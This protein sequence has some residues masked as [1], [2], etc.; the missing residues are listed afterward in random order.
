MKKLYSL[1]GI[2]LFL[3]SATVSLADSAN[4][5]GK[6]NT[7]KILDN[8]EIE[9]TTEEINI[10]IYP[11]MKE[12]EEFVP[13]ID[14]YTE[15]EVIYVFTNL[16][17]TE[18]T[19][20]MGFPEK[21][22]DIDE[23]CFESMENVSDNFANQYKLNEF[24]A[25]DK[26]KNYQIEFRNDKTSVTPGVN[27][28]IYQVDFAPNEK[29][30]IT[31]KYWISNSSYKGSS[32][33]FSYILETGA[34]W[35]NSIGEIDVN[36]YFKDGLSVYDIN[37]ATP[38]GYTLNK[39][40]NSIHHKFI[41][42]EPT[43]ND[44]L[45]INYA[46]NTILNDWFQILD[47]DECGT[48]SS[49]FPSKN[50]TIYNACMAQ[51]NDTNT[52]WVEG[53][54]GNGI[55]EWFEYN[56][57]Y[58]ETDKIYNQI[59]IINGYARDNDIWQKNNRIKK[60][61]FTTTNN[62]TINIELEDTMDLQTFVYNETFY[63]NP[64]TKIYIDEIYQGSKYNDTALSE[65]R[66][67]GLG[68][69]IIN[70]NVPPQAQEGTF[71]DVLDN[72]PFQE[73]I[74]QLFSVQIIQGYEDGTYKPT[75]LI[76]RAEFTKIIIEA[77]IKDMNQSSPYEPPMGG[78]NCFSDVQDQWFAKYICGAKKGGIINGYS[79][80]TFRPS[81]SINLAEALKIVLE[82]K[83]KYVEDINLQESVVWYQKYFDVADL[84]DLFEKIAHDPAKNI[85]RG[86]MAQIIFVLFL[87]RG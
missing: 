39:E 15:V 65:I 31:N 43:N 24:K 78:E 45:E 73:A 21:C 16:S 62:K 4:L 68:K 35:K 70:P 10:N 64:D 2:C 53:V 74:E 14:G 75:Y 17:E 29:K 7:V 46:D 81:D 20:T 57:T 51:D 61:H 8:S 54:D 76:N 69:G 6:G 49:F 48:S 66:F 47:A 67:K 50:E 37:H 9:M 41:N 1:L 42:L 11:S 55:G 44:N 80:G 32:R 84:T 27:W 71:S 87:P 23:Q 63:L 26:T 25:F 59:Q 3:C 77:I 58:E 38:E 22:S 86:E 5:G 30:T 56:T 18:T 19:V 83:N 34:S 12:R 33:W 72:N 85:T 13:K 36:I 82:A 79:D 28:Y 40:T 52:A 60:L